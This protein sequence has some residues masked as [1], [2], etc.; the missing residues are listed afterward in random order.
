MDM[1]VFDA[2]PD[3]WLDVGID[4]DDRAPAGVSDAAIARMDS[5][6]LQAAVQ[7]C[8]RCG[9]CRTRQTAVPG[10]GAAN[11]AWMVVATAPG[12]AEEQAVQPVAGEAA[13]LL[14]NMLKAIGAGAESG[15]S[16]VTTLVKCRPLDAQGADRAPT[17]EEL[18]ACRPYLERELA[19]T[20]ARTILTLGHTAGKGLLGAAARGKVLRLGDVPVVATYHPADLLRKPEDKRKVWAD[21]CLTLSAAASVQEGGQHGG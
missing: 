18:A 19:L 4:L 8:T 16:Y 20:G 10:Q 15:T 6:A 9:L 17:P 1:P 5:A 2:D 7:G 14:D 13:I 11:A 12:A 3:A 21:L